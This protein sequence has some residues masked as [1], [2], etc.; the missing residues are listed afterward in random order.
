MTVLRCCL[1]LHMPC[2]RSQSRLQDYSF[3]IVLPYAK[4]LLCSISS[5]SGT[6]RPKSIIIIIIN[7]QTLDSRVAGAGI[8]RSCTA[9]PNHT[10]HLTQRNAD[11]NT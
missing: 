5:T 3:K 2:Q 9:I 7:L 1:C 10:R 4:Q 11:A 6:L 8:L